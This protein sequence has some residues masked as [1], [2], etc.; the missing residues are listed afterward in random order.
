MY[1]VRNPLSNIIVLSH[2]RRRVGKTKKFH[3]GTE[4]EDGTKSRICSEVEDA[5]D[6]DAVAWHISP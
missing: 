2:A 6:V 4:Q 3:M 5:V 1:L